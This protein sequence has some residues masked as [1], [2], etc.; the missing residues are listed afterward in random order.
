TSDHLILL[1]R[2]GKPVIVSTNEVDSSLHPPA[3]VGVRQQ[4]PVPAKGAPQPDEVRQR[5]LDSKTGREWLPNTPPVMMPYPAN[6]DEYGNTAIQPGSVFSTDPLSQAVQ[7]GKYALSEAGLRYSLYQSLTMVSMSDVASGSSALQY[8]TATFF[9]KWAITEVGEPA[10]AGWLSTEVNV[11]LGLSPASRAQTPQANLGSIVNPQATVFRPNGI[12]VS[13]LAW[14]QS[15]MDGKLVLLVGQVDQSNYLDA[16]AYANNSQGQFLNSAFVNSDV[17]PFAFNNLGLNL[18]Y[19]PGQDW[20]VMFGTGANNQ[21]P[22]QSPFNNLSFRNWSY[23][24]EFGLTP[25]MML[26]LGP[27]VYRLQPFIATVDGVTQVGIGFNAQ[28]KL[29][30]NSPFAWFGRFGVGGNQVTLDGAAAQIATGFAMQAPLKY[31]GLF[32]KLSND[33]LGIGFVWSRPSAV[34]P[35]TAHANEYGVETTYVLQLTPLAS[36]QPDFQVIWNP[37]DNPAA[38]HN[39]IFQLQL[40][41]TW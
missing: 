17:L 19:Q 8:Y 21:A 13:E 2:L 28:Q 3:A 37:A 24:L 26:G 6:L 1:D 39:L 30:T 38:D 31:A 9:G 18:Q 34:M 11:Q 20:Y 22:G 14:Q 12:W 25:K 32:P 27:G 40:N 36:V 23:L 15:L 35:P 16:N 41:L 4:V 29:G 10:R 5:I 7:A 33:Y